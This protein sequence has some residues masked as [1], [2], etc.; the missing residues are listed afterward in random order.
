MFKILRFEN[1]S[2][3]GYLLSPRIATQSYYYCYY[4]KKKKKKKNKDN[5]H[6]N[7]N[8]NDPQSAF[9]P[10]RRHQRG[11]VLPH[12]SNFLSSSSR[13]SLT[14]PL[15]STHEQRRRW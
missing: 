11:R 9:I 13:I 14:K 3:Y 2:L 10:F 12:V 4:K 8:N 5:N 15:F 1:Y 6:N 7:N